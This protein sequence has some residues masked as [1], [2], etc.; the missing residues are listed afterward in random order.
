MKEIHQHLRQLYGSCNF[1]AGEWMHFFR[2]HNYFELMFGFFDEREKPFI[3]T[4]AIDWCRALRSPG[5]FTAIG[6]GAQF[7]MYLMS[8]YYS[9]DPEFDYGYIEAIA[10]VEKTINNIDACSR[11]VW[12]GLCAV[13]DLAKKQAHKDLIVAFQ[14]WGKEPDRLLPTKSDTMLFSQE[15]IVWVLDE[16]KFQE[17]QFIENHNKI[18][19]D[20]VKGAF[21]RREKWWEQKRK[22]MED[23]IANR[24]GSDAIP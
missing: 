8:E 11:P 9:A 2:D 24:R 5:L 4:I 23:E 3:Y 12:T 16:L 22:E 15:E 19:V 6:C 13:P 20:V 7:A 18:M 21:E 14:K 10:A 1:S 17:K